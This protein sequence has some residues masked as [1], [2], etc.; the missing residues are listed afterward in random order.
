M[1]N[2]S[3]WSS[4]PA[5][6]ICPRLIPSGSISQTK[7]MTSHSSVSHFSWHS[8]ILPDLVCHSKRLSGF[9][10]SRRK[11]N[12][13]LTSDLLSS[14]VWAIVNK[15]KRSKCPLEQKAPHEWGDIWKLRPTQI[16]DKS[17]GDESK[18]S[19]CHHP[20]KKVLYTEVLKLF[21]WHIPLLSMCF[22]SL[23]YTL[24]QHFP[25]QRSI[26]EPC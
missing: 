21:I 26:D 20:R 5:I 15:S 7:K 2:T 8:T 6:K 1:I 4:I 13:I 25:H 14:N 19:Y 22:Y 11:I 9:F 10:S 18:T 17:A 24:F 23:L 12:F 16:W 3:I